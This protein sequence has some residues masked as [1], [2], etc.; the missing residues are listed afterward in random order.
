LKKRL[1]AVVLQTLL[2]AGFTQTPELPDLPTDPL[3]LGSELPALLP[4]EVP[5]LAPPAPPPPPPPPPFRLRLSP[6]AIE[7]AILPPLEDLMQNSLAA[8]VRVKV[9]EIRF[10]G[11]KIYSTGALRQ[12]IRKLEGREV[13]MDDL[14]DARQAITLHY[15]KAG[16]VN[17]G[18]LLED[19]DVSQ[20]IIT[21]TVVEGQLSNIVVEGNRWH[22][23]WW[24]RN[25]VRRYAARLLNEA[26]L[27]EGLQVMRQLP[28]IQQINAE[29]LPG[30]KPGEAILHLKVKE[31]HPFRLSLEYSNSR[32][33]S[34]GSQ[35][36]MLQAA[37]LNLT[38]HNDPLVLSWGILRE[39]DS[40][41]EYSG[42][43]NVSGSYGF[44]I[45]PWGTILELRASRTDSSVIEEAFRVLDI[46]SETTE[47]GATVRQ[48]L[49]TSLQWDVSV[50]AGFERKMNDTFLLSRPFS[51]SPGAIDGSTEIDVLRVGFEVAHRSTT[52]VFAFRSTFSWGLDVFDATIN[53]GTISSSV[54]GEGRLP[55]GRFFTWVGQGQ[56]VRR[57]ND[58]G[59]LAVARISAQLSNSPLLSLEQFPIG[60]VN[61]VRG[62]RENTLV[63]DNAVVG[64][65]ELR[66]PV[67]AVGKE[68]L[69]RPVLTV[70]PFF[71][72]GSGWRHGRDQGGSEQDTLASVGVGVLFEPIRAVQAQLYW[73]Y[74]LN[75]DFVIEEDRNLQDYGIH[76]AIRVSAF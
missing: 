14:E 10:T 36:V 45:S 51:L 27:R 52:Q 56:Y 13:T 8:A 46:T 43:E 2:A 40:G 71:D 67:W 1:L 20:G 42:F 48:P 62:Y 17:S 18:A 49:Y 68:D 4:D 16:F 61:S 69:R 53:D 22:R 55:D 5:L 15:V 32:P 12:V 72:L 73:G 66:V 65:L 33:P 29:L 23:G 7:E 30:G 34:V 57:L 74:A 25:E 26:R 37:D 47:Y 9:K 58:S 60:G 6:G 38:G 50:S 75:R 76:F 28:G 21:I 11:N 24:L 70:V 19:Q 59:W 64:T 31:R 41:L 39:S 44:P 3:P 35:V 54:V 63:R